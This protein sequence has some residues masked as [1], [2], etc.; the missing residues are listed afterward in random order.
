M[1]FEL[2]PEARKI[3]DS[4]TFEANGGAFVNDEQWP[5]FHWNITI[6][7]IEKQIQTTY[8]TGVAHHTIN[9]KTDEA[10][11][12]HF[13][14][15][16]FWLTR[17]RETSRTVYRHPIT[18][19]ATPGAQLQLIPTPPKLLDVLHSLILD[20]EASDY[21]F[22]E[23]CTNF[24]Y[25]TDSIKALSTYRACEEIAEKMRKV[26]TREEFATLREAFQDY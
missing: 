16:K 15:G 11:K 3:V 5:H 9:G 17:E 2:S 22:G 12:A 13:L 18:P 25:D 1:S 14:K 20:S 19:G 21:S 7:R 10:T 26:F 23:W 8:K 4:L 24:G 6:S